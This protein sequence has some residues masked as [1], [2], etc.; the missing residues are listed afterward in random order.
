MRRLKILHVLA[1]AAPRY[2]G[3]PKAC[4]EM[5]A[6]VAALGH[7]VA[8]FTTN[9]DG[10]GELDVPLDRPVFRDGEE[11]RFFPIEWPRFWATSRPMARALRDRIREVDLV[12]V[13]S[14]YLFHGLA[15]GHE[16]LVYKFRTMR[17]CEDGPEIP[18][19]TPD[20]ERVTP[21]GRFLRRTSLEN[22]PN[23]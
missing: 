2:G 16:I 6:A 3:P 22:C 21:L 13:H 17:V 7:E 4:L 8:V 14:L 10:P 1:N 9:Q 19:A 15:D 12:H 11:L 18:Q 23:S 5:A 20:D